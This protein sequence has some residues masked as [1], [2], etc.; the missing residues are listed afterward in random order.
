MADSE[1]HSL[2]AHWAP[3]RPLPESALSFHP[4]DVLHDGALAMTA[5]KGCQVSQLLLHVR[6][7]L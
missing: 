4:G 3:L 6:Q 7:S 2:L 1:E 5:R